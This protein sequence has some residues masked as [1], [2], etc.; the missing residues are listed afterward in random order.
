M[1]LTSC[2]GVVPNGTPWNLESTPYGGWERTLVTQRNEMS[3]KGDFCDIF[4]TTQSIT[5]NKVSLESMCQYRQSPM[6]ILT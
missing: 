1:I 4:S 2:H 3:A 5:L 6:K